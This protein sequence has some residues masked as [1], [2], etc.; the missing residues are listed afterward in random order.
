MSRG[1]GA[2]DSGVRASR[3]LL[4]E[5][6]RLEDSVHLGLPERAALVALLSRVG[7]ADVPLYATR[8]NGHL[9]EAFMGDEAVGTCLDRRPRHSWRR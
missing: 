1:S 7:T 9:L 3:A 5:P 2:P 6:G 4:R 8:A